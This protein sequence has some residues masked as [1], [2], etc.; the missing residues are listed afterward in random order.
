MV[1]SFDAYPKY[2]INVKIVQFEERSKSGGKGGFLHFFPPKD[3]IV[4]DIVIELFV[5]EFAIDFLL[6]IE[7]PILDNVLKLYSAVGW[8]AE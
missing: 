2:C 3:W 6:F 8:S 1:K 7:P 4:F 5:I